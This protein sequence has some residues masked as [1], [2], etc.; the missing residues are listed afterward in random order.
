[1]T[2]P[3]TLEKMA[4]AAD[5]A[6]WAQSDVLRAA[7]IACGFGTAASDEARSYRLADMSRASAVLTAEHSALSPPPSVPEGWKLVEQ[8]PDDEMID[9]GQR[10]EEQGGSV[11]NIWGAMFDAA[12]TQPTKGGDAKSE[13]SSPRSPAYDAAPDASVSGASDVADHP[14]A[15][16]SGEEVAN[17]RELAD[18]GYAPGSYTCNCRGCGKRFTGDKRAIRCLRCARVAR[19]TPP[20]ATPTAEALKIAVEAGER[21]RKA[22]SLLLQ[23]AEG[24]A[25]NHY[26]EDWYLHGMPGWLRD[27]QSEIEAASDALAWIKR[28]IGDDHA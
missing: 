22:A 26:G 28:V 13:T 2:P 20:S 8:D 9:A 21:L 25:R 7:S 6:W 19:D 11:A 24:C 10:V 16:A 1:M 12:P 18:Y 15:G 27:T 17:P 3:E 23:N 4:R 5:P 14:S